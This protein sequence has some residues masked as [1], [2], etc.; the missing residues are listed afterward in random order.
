VLAPGTY[1]FMCTIHLE[2][3]GQVTVVA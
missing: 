2:M 3:T 1:Q